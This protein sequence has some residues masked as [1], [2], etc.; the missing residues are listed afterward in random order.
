MNYLI[1]IIIQLF[2]LIIIIILSK[3]HNNFI[4]LKLK[5]YQQE[6]FNYWYIFS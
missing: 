3:I 5:I 2:K 4:K 6:C 1:I